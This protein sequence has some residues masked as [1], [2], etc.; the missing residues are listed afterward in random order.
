MASKI[1]TKTELKKHIIKA[2]ICMLIVVVV[3]V[4]AFCG[5]WFGYIVKPNPDT[6]KFVAPETIQLNYGERLKSEDWRVEFFNNVIDKNQL[7]TSKEFQIS[8]FDPEKIG[9]QTIV[10]TFAGQTYEI[11]VTIS[12]QQLDAPT[13]SLS[14]NK[15]VWNAVENAQ[16]YAIYMG[17][18]GE[19]MAVVA[20]TT[21]TEFDLRTIGVLGEYD[22]CVVAKSDKEQ[23]AQSNC[24]NIIEA[25]LVDNVNNVSYDGKKIQWS[26]VDNATSYTLNVNN[27]A[28]SSLTDCFYEIDLEPGVN[29]V[30]VSANFADEKFI[31]LEP[32]TVNIKRLFAISEIKAENGTI[33]WDAIDGADTYDVYL[34]GELIGSQQKTNINVG[35]LTHGIYDFAI[36]AKGAGYVSSRISHFEALI[37]VVPTVD[38]NMLL[39]ELTE[40]CLFNLFIDD[41]IV[42]GPVKSIE[43]NLDDIITKAG[44]HEIYV[45]ALRENI[46][47]GKTPVITITKL[48]APVIAIADGAFICTGGKN[49]QWYKNGEPFD[50]KASSLVDVG[51]YTITAKSIAGDNELDSSLSNTINVTRLSAPVITF[52]D[53]VLICTGGKNVQWYK[54]GV[55]FDGQASSLVDAGTYTITAKSIAG[56]N[57]LDSATS[58]TITITKLAAPTISFENGELRAAGGKNVQWYM[59]DE[60]FDGDINE[61]VDVGTYTITAKS[62]SGDNELDSATSNTIA[63]TKLAAPTI[64]FENGELGAAGGKNV[65]WYKNGVPFDGKASSLVNAGTYTITAKS[66]AGENELDS[67]LSDEL[68]ITKLEAPVI[69]IADGA[70][71]CTGGKNVQWYMNDEPFD[72]QAS[73]LVDVGT[74]TIT[75]KSIAGKN[76]LDSVLSNELTITKLEAPV[77][78]FEEDVLICTGGKNVQWYKNGVP[79]DGNINELVN[80]GTY[81]ITAKSIAGENELDSATSNTFTITKLAAP[82]I[83][84]ENGELSAVGGKNV[85]WYL[86]GEPFDGQASSLVDAGTYTITAKSIAGKNELDSVISNTINVARLSAPVITFEDGAFRC[87]G[88]KNVQWYKNGELFDGQA[89]SLVDAGTYTITAKSI[90]GENELDSAISNTINVARLSAPVIAFEDGVLICTGGKNVQWYMDDEPFDGQASSLVDAGTYTI[91]AKSI[92]GDNELD[93]AISNTITITKLAA[94]TISFENGE[95][96][97]VGGKNVQWYL[98]G[99]L[100]NDALNANELPSGE[101]EIYA[102]NTSDDLFAIDSNASNTL[103]ITKLAEP[104]ISLGD[105]NKIEVQGGD[106]DIAYYYDDGKSFGGDISSLPAG[107]HDVYA[108]RVSSDDMTI[109]SNIS[110]VVKVYH[111]GVEVTV[112][113]TTAYRV[114]INVSHEI[115]D[116]NFDCIVN[117]EFYNGDELIDQ[118]DDVNVA[119]L[120]SYNRGGTIATKIVIHIKVICPL[121][122]ESGAIVKEYDI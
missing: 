83:S 64:S 85:Q 17:V 70:F 115:E 5:V 108:I 75:A 100:L 57:E 116:D 103:N 11:Q 93:S 31:C 47:I 84:F 105:N 20:E 26:A 65:Q 69:A 82:T 14:G 34:D 44:A 25:C 119:N 104:Q 40:D 51:T 90:A 114:R 99:V 89:S 36:L 79:F 43:I 68:T 60:P 66:I 19:E 33:V 2:S 38:G 106:E 96:S 117:V 9:T 61:L 97:A 59:N 76:E 80:A 22:I 58:N 110:N 15:I 56:D 10:L 45:Q 98:N 101:H 46:S 42:L 107:M 35:H 13:A 92:A 30:T 53:G 29:S 120:V 27:R 62:I 121:G 67:V 113:P 41:Q 1:A 63:I 87:T 8:E 81:T 37:N 54:N 118:L 7:Q 102:I 32:K 74:Y 21:M 39:L 86:N 48:D 16:G 50:G 94:P 112:S 18:Y 111:A 3:L 23:Y 88:G 4:S 71:R 91:T 72:G 52:E 24:S 73:S 49:V 95:L 78:A 77:I 109:N 28:I 6:I 12:P 122:Y 55:P